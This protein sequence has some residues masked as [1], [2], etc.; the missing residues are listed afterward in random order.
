MS[1]EPTVQEQQAEDFQTL[2]NLL[3]QQTDTIPQEQDR[4]SFWTP[5]E[6]SRA[7]QA[8]IKRAL[9]NGWKY[10]EGLL[11]KGG[12]K[13]RPSAVVPYK[14]FGELGY[15]PAGDAFAIRLGAE[16]IRSGPWA[17]R[18]RYGEHIMDHTGQ[19]LDPNE[20]PEC[21]GSPFRVRVRNV[22]PNAPPWEQAFTYCKRCVTREMFL[23]NEARVQVSPD[24]RRRR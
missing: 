10:R 21:Q 16:L 14:T 11:E 3:G 24:A 20:C 4:S 15:N 17:G 2:R 9:D 18:Y 22:R 19:F 5:L 6:I 7:I 23:E 8:S 1:N 13:A 12:V